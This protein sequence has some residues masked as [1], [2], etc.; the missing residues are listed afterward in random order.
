M[1][2]PDEVRKIRP[3]GEKLYPSRLWRD[4]PDH[5][6]EMSIFRPR[7]G[8]FSELLAQT[9]PGSIFRDFHEK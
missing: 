1:Q 6:P 7:I 8:R 2:S 3:L 9:F 4:I 5:G